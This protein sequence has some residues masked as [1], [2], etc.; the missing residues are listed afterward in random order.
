MNY[1]SFCLTSR[2]HIFDFGARNF[3]CVR[4]VV[5]AVSLHKSF[6]QNQEQDIRYKKEN[7]NGHTLCLLVQDT[8]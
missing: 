6:Q 3:F 4:L 1:N 2:V 5:M 8:L 7:G